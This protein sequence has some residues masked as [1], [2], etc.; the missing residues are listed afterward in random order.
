M[1]PNPIHVFASRRRKL[2]IEEVYDVYSA[3]PNAKM[4]KTGRPDEQVSALC[5][6]SSLMINVDYRSIGLPFL[7]SSWYSSSSSSSSS[8]VE[9]PQSSR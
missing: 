6:H 2:D 5:F 9:Q 3:P 1:N 8:S 7:L 4:K